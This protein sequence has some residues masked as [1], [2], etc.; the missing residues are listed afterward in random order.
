MPGTRPGM[1]TVLSLPVCLEAIRVRPIDAE[2]FHFGGVKGEFFQRELHRPVF[3][4]PFDIGVELRRG[5]TTVELIR[6]ELRH[7]DAVRGEA[8][9]RHVERGRNIT[10][11][12]YER[13]HC[14]RF[15]LR[16]PLG[17]ARENEKARRIMRLLLDILL[18]EI[19][20]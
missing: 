15:A 12:K 19:E 8:A 14:W 9:E 6:F 3:R 11:A 7:V 4:M 2:D 20:S 17:L 10:H 1:T 18:Q 5:E 16:R 13:R